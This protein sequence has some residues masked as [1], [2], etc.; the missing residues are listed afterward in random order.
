MARYVE[1]ERFG[2]GEIRVDGDTLEIFFFRLSA[3][4]RVLRSAPMLQPLV[5]THARRRRVREADVRRGEC[6][7]C[8]DRLVVTEHSRIDGTGTRLLCAAGHARPIRGAEITG[9]DD[10]GSSDALDSRRVVSGCF[11]MGKRR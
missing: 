3:T 11:G 7:A 6:A 2:I 4:K 1:H 9:P 5:E 8:G 10:D